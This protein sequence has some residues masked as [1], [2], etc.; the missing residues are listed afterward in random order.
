VILRAAVYDTAG[1][2][3]LKLS[4]CVTVVF[5]LFLASSTS[6]WTVRWGGNATLLVVLVHSD[7]TVG[8]G[9]QR[10]F[11][12]VVGALFSAG[13]AWATT[14]LAV[15]AATT[16]G[17]PGAREAL[18]LPVVMVSM[19]LFSTVFYY[20]IA[21]QSRFSYVG[22]ICA[23]V[24]QA[25]VY[26][27][28]LYLRALDGP[29]DVAAVDDFTQ[30]RLSGT[31][32]A[33]GV[34]S[35]SQLLLYPNLARS[36][37]KVDLADALLRTHA[38][39]LLLTSSRAA[40]AGDASRTATTAV[41]LAEE[42]DLADAVGALRVQLGFAVAEPRLEAAYPAA[43][44][45]S[46]L[47]NLE[48]VLDH[49]TFAS[50]I[51]QG[52]VERVRHGEVRGNL[53]SLRVA[54]SVQL[55][56]IAAAVRGGMALPPRLPDALRIRRKLLESIVYHVQRAHAEATG[57][58]PPR[59]GINAEGDPGGGVP[60][61]TGRAALRGEGG[62]PGGGT[63]DAD[64]AAAVA[65]ADAAA[66][67]PTP[68]TSTDGASS[69]GCPAVD[70]DEVFP[71]SVSYLAYIGAL[72]DC[73]GELTNMTVAA[74]QLVGVLEP[75]TSCD[76]D[77]EASDGSDGGGGEGEG[78][79]EGDDDVLRRHGRGRDSD[80]VYYNGDID[81]GYAGD[82]EEGLAEKR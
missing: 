33:L 2:Y 31:A 21:K 27:A 62:A 76:S 59:R 29:V 54:V 23:V 1:R 10:M 67:Q 3:A 20:I 53:A 11:F 60:P 34:I 80:D 19:A 82:L 49:L 40:E 70:A 15:L 25:I 52:G 46:L 14:R 5:A 74:R 39:Y 9:I 48:A 43:I 47:T 56:A 30:T 7:P 32:L 73:Y 58:A 4:A 61:D 57:V 38:V 28:Y 18:A 44:M 41:L 71:F 79:R 65:D 42:R 26:P 24:G 55:F 45:G 75:L 13:W 64:A 16:D 63:A 81:D 72:G 69:C 37:I 77:E 22:I 6:E 8:G 35:V 12:L 66:E 50:L 36:R 51:L 78:G 68:S 17:V